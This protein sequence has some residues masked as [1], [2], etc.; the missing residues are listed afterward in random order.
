MNKSVILAVLLFIPMF[1]FSQNAL[2]LDTALNNST[3]YL[4]GRIPPKSKVVVLNFTSNWPQ[5]SEY[6]IEELIG[7]IVN[8]GT[9]TVVDRRNLEVI[10]QEMDFQLSG[11]VS[12]E[13]AQSIGQ[14]L[15]AQT[16]ISGAITAI[17]NTYRLRIRAI[18]VETAQIQGMQNVDVVQDSRLAALTGTAYVGPITKPSPSTPAKD[19]TPGTNSIILPSAGWETYNNN[20]TVKMNT[21]REYIEGQEKE[22]LNLE[23]ELMRKSG[24]K[25]GQFI[26]KNETVIQKLKSGSGVRFK[27]LGDGRKW[28]FK[29]GTTETDID[30][31]HYQVTI[32]ARQGRVL[33]ID[34]PYSRLRQPEWGKRVRFNKPNIIFLVFERGS[35]TESGKS[36][37]KVFDFEIY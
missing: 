1:I 14:K 2:T 34:I 6:I 11:E 16:I 3:A 28:F 21:T 24:W 35:E 32:T 20:S 5:L 27:I 19:T 15:G 36:L 9:L 18:A 33:A 26:L 23:V 7:Y 12:D 10:R 22:V 4:N 17:G 37:I 29:I 13:T 31:A 30:Y 25:Y 8:E